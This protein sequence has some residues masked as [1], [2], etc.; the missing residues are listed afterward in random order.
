VDHACQLIT[1]YAQGEMMM[2]EFDEGIPI[3][4]GYD[5]VTP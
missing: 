4:E 1:K 5:D 2:G 3:G